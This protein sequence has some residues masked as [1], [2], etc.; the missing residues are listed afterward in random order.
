MRGQ[1]QLFFLEKA[2]GK[3][4]KQ[5]HISNVTFWDLL[6]AHYWV[7]ATVERIFMDFCGVFRAVPRLDAMPIRFVTWSN[8]HVALLNWI[9][10]RESHEDLKKGPEVIQ[11]TLRSGKNWLGYASFTRVKRP[12]LRVW[13]N[14][15]ALQDSPTHTGKTRQCV[16]KIQTFKSKT[17]W[18]EEDVPLKSVLITSVDNVSILYW[19]MPGKSPQYRYFTS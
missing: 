9:K 7:D 15:R 3:Q 4:N 5:K 11:R 17:A 6:Y 18:L 12:N 8:T 1:V 16:Q 2:L 13:H 19:N 10:H 14:F